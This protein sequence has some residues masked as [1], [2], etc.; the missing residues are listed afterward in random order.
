MNVNALWTPV[1]A[2]E[3]ESVTGGMMVPVHERV[4]NEL[5]KKIKGLGAGNVSDYVGEF[6]VEGRI[7]YVGK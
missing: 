4:E 2:A 5:K 3:L 1:T 6:G 7:P